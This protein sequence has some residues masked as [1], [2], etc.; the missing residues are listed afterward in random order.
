VLAEYHIADRAIGHLLDV[1]DQRVPATRIRYAD[2]VVYPV[3][4]VSEGGVAL[5]NVGMLTV[6]KPC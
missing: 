3:K 6:R 1:E 5:V 2:N 4:S